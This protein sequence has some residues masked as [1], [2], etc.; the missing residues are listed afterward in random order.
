LACAIE[1]AGTST[2]AF[3]GEAQDGP[4]DDVVL[5]TSAQEHAGTLGAAGHLA[6]AARG[7]FANVEPG[8]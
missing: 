4:P 8:P 6:A 5:V 1:P 3:V 7:F 2:A